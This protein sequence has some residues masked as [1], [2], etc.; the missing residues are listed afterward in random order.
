MC[1]FSDIKRLYLLLWLTHVLLASQYFLLLHIIEHSECYLIPSCIKKRLFAAAV[2]I[3]TIP[4]ISL[5]VI[6]YTYKSNV[7]FISPFIAF[8]YKETFGLHI[9]FSFVS[10]SVFTYFYVP[11]SRGQGQ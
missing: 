3:L 10:P 4:S 1:V 9:V 8:C 2:H 7:Y 11:L 6:L 5:Y